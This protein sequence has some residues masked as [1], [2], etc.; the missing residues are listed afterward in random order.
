MPDAKCG[1]SPLKACLWHDLIGGLASHVRVIPTGST[2]AIA[3]AVLA[4]RR[5]ASCEHECKFLGTLR[6]EIENP[7]K[8]A[9][10]GVQLFGALGDVRGAL[11]LAEAISDKSHDAEPITLF[12]RMGD[13][14][15]RLSEFSVPA[16]LS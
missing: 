3:L 5:H 12:S 11:A 8:R 6:K 2:S 15:R 14:A 13:G 4:G 9:T 1:G 16:R 10:K 7:N